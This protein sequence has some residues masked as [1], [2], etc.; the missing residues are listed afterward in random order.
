MAVQATSIITGYFI[1]GILIVA[2]II[3][4]LV[5][6]VVLITKICKVVDHAAVAPAA[7]APAYAAAPP[8][9]ASYAAAS[10]ISH[11]DAIRLINVDDK[12]AAMIMAIVSD[13]T[14]IPVDKLRFRAIRYM[15]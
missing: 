10:A 8:P 9:V 6:V 13:E 14:K 7:P 2:A 15:D 11:S 4:L 1:I 5:A 3:A 12:T